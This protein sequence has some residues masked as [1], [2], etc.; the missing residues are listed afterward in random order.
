MI[1]SNETGTQLRW[2]AINK[3]QQLRVARKISNG[4]IAEFNIRLVLW[5]LPFPKFTIGSILKLPV[6]F[7]ELHNP[8]CLLTGSKSGN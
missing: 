6:G 2:T 3:A 5:F 7:F 4:C 1:A 8:Y